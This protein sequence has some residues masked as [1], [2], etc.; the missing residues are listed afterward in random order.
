V[1]QATSQEPRGAGCH[2]L[3]LTAI[4]AIGIG[5]FCLDVDLRYGFG[6][7]LLYGVLVSGPSQ[8]HV[9]AG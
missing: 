7:G 4:V 8:V 9:R 3:F 6:N 2:Q 1:D 5:L